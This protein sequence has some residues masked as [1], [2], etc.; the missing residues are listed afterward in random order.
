M[1][2]YI[3]G[4]N[5]LFRML[6]AS[7]EDLQ[8]QREMVIQ[9]LNKKIQILQ[10]DITLVF[11]AQYQFGDTTRSH[12]NYLEILFTSKG[13]TADDFIINELK[14]TDSPR[15]ETVVTSDKKL[16]WRARRKHAHT[17][18]VEEFLEW[19][20][21]RYKNVKKQKKKEKKV[22]LT[23]PP[24]APAK[25]AQKPAVPSKPTSKASA[26][27]CFDFYLHE[28]EKNFEEVVLKSQPLILPETAP[29]PPI[30]KKLRKPKEQVE[31]GISDME[32]WHKI[33]EERLTKKDL[34]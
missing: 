19:L 32:R 22:V 26:E 29:E 18:S 30:H 4:Y 6:R 11:D 12:L 21:R 23:L 7:D 28:F 2:Y 9:D 16:A 10:L 8:T 31:K 15:Q 34:E 17:E 5:L 25:P 20:N 33:F 14:S 13:E 27:E 1:H 24:V 3:D